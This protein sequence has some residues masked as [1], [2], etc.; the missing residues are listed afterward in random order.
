MNKLKNLAPLFIILVPLIVIFFFVNPMP[1]SLAYHNFADAH[2]I[3]GIKNFHNVMTNIVFIILGTMGLRDYIKSNRKDLN[4]LI[5]ILS[6]LLVGPGSAYYHYTPNNQTLFW[7][8][9]PMTMGFISLTCFALFEMHNVKTKRNLYLLLAQ[10][11]GLS[12][13]F[14]WVKFDDLRFYLWVQFTPIVLMLYIA[15][16]VSSSSLRPRNLIFAVVFY[17]AAKMTESS[18]IKI[19]ESIDYSGH[20]IKHLLA[21]VAVYFLITIRKPKTKHA[22]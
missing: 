5:F 9:L 13:L 22:K 7:D 11:I 16:I 4:W 20:S 14:Y 8:R 18:D 21:G 1:Q 17:V 15:F 19:F 10:I 3:F 6:I 12:T 2:T